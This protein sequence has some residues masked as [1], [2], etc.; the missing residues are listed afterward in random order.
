[1][2]GTM[3][4]PPMFW[5]RTSLQMLSQ[6]LSSFLLGPSS[7]V[8]SLMSPSLIGSSWGWQHCKCCPCKLGLH[9]W[10]FWVN[11][12]WFAL[13]G[14]GP[15]ILVRCPEH[16]NHISILFNEITKTR[17]IPTI[18][19]KWNE[20]DSFSKIWEISE[21]ETWLSEYTFIWRVGIVN[22]FENVLGCSPTK[23]QTVS[24]LSRYESLWFICF[25]NNYSFPRPNV[26]CA[27]GCW[28]VMIDA[29]SG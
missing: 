16:K 12:D 10:E 3:G 22:S 26:F 18:D 1:M 25:F 24:I 2:V 15:K 7:L 11:T 19:R 27:G 23:M 8:K 21:N 17:E 13:W 20:K 9:C 6:G 14:C 28:W 4:R 5:L 29:W